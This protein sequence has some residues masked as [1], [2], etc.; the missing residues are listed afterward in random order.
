MV[1]ILFIIMFGF[2]IML[3]FTDNYNFYGCLLSFMFN[4]MTYSVFILFLAGKTVISKPLID[5]KTGITNDQNLRETVISRS[6]LICKNSFL[7]LLLCSLPF[8]IYALTRKDLFDQISP[9]TIFVIAN[10]ILATIFILVLS[11]ILLLYYEK[12]FWALLSISGVI[13]TSFIAFV[14]QTELNLLLLFAAV[15]I[16][17]YCSSFLLIH[18]KEKREKLNL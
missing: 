9:I 15:I 16:I 11:T 7:W 4:T 6:K 3:P 17:A 8:I 18:K 1:Y 13:F 12:Q 5:I 10:G 2:S 14:P